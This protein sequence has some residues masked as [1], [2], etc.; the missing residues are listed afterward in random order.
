MEKTLAQVKKLF[1][2]LC[3]PGKNSSAVLE[4]R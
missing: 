4:W 2:P 3:P 1:V